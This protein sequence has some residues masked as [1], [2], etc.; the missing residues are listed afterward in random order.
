MA[1]I[2]IKDLPKDQTISR[3]ELSKLIGGASYSH[4]FTR[5]DAAGIQFG[6]ELSHV[7]ARAPGGCR[8]TIIFKDLS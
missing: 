7:I 1:R 2:K 4:Q 6:R 8:R 5:F 3:E